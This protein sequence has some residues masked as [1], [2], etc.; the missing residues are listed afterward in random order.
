MCSRVLPEPHGPVGAALW[1]VCLLTHKLSL[2]IIAPT[3]GGSARL[4]WP[5]L[6]AGYILR[7]FPT[8]RQKLQKT[9]QSKKPKQL[10]ASYDIW[11]LDQDYSN[12]KSQLPR[13]PHGANSNN[14]QNEVISILTAMVTSTVWLWTASHL[15]FLVL[16]S[17]LIILSVS[18][19]REVN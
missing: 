19:P 18:M 8:C 7:W 17:S 3:H 15:S 13:S 12:K 9:T 14:F 11:P 5:T 6:V 10:V 4:S 2:V 16:V 1:I